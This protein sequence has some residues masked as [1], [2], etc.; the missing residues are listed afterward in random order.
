MT[1]RVYVMLLTGCV[2]AALGQL[3]FKVGASGRVSLGSF[4][5]G[6]VFLGLALYAVGTVLWIAS[7]SQAKLT[8]V[9]PFTALT[10]VLVYVLGISVLGEAVSTQALV[11]VAFVLSGLFLVAFA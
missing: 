5:N 1:W 2:C 8:S 3:L 4:M 7:L 11:G 6:W 10:F 9:Y